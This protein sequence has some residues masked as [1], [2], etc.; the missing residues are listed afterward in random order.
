MPCEQL[1][2]L[3][4]AKNK[5]IK[6]FGRGHAFSVLK[7]RA[8]AAIQRSD[9]HAFKL[10]LAGLSSSFAASSGDFLV[11]LVHQWIAPL[12]LFWVAACVS[13]PRCCGKKQTVAKRDPQ[14]GESVAGRYLTR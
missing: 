2:S 7:L 8:Y 6:L 13:S 11:K 12:S 4:T 1:S 5:Y 3:A 10:D 9:S 14:N